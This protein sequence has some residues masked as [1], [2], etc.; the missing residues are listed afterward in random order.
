MLTIALLAGGSPAS[1]I[2]DQ[3]QEVF[4]GSAAVDIQGSL[5]QTFTPLVSRQLDHV[6]LHICDEYG[7][8]TV[9]ATISIVQTV[10]GAPTGATLGQVVVSGFT[11]DTA[12]D[13]NN[14]GTIDVSG[15]WNSIDFLPESVELTAGTLY[16]IVISNNDPS[17]LTPP[18]DALFAQVGIVAAEDLY[19]QGVLWTSR[20]STWAPLALES[21]PSGF[22]DAVF[23]T[24]MVPEP[25]TLGLLIMGGLAFLRVRRRFG[26]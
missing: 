14:D 5:A 24:Y 21:Y 20:S 18:T 19:S 7:N 23:R 4:N 6:D 13:V 3:S 26:R 17:Y 25:A 10:A 1:P 22:S 2:L 16:A 12:Y 9:P 11:I 15:G 8:P